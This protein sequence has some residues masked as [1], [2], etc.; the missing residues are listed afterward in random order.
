MGTFERLLQDFRRG[1]NIDLYVT[2]VAALA[3]AILN[4]LGV[5]PVASLTAL[6]LTLLGLLFVAQLTNRHKLEELHDLAVIAAGQAQPF[7]D[8]FPGEFATRLEAARELWLAGTHHSAALTAYYQLLAD[9]VAKGGR[10]RALLV[11]PD[12]A[13]SGMAAMRFAGNV[14]RDHERVRIRASL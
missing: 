13:A 3:L 4:V 9:K 1:E 10:V 5:V 6:V 14:D 7:V 11:D 2:I 12:G 8:E